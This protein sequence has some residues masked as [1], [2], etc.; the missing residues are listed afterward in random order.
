M[1][2][3]FSKAEVKAQA[4]RVFES[5]SKLGI[6]SGGAWPAHCSLFSAEKHSLAFSHL[7]GGGIIIPEYVKISRMA[8]IL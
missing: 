7:G 2:F 8:Q 6:N 4:G 1:V 5:V 3:A